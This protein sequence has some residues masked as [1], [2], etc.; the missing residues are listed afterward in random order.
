ML[1]PLAKQ[2]L[3]SV[4]FVVAFTLLLAV[5][6]LGVLHAGWFIGSVVAIALATIYA[7]VAG[8]KREWYRFD[9]PA[10]ALSLAAVAM[11]LLATESRDS[12]LMF[13]ALGPVLNF[14]QQVAIRGVVLGTA[15]AMLTVVWPAL[16]SSPG[17]NLL[18]VASAL[19][20]A[21][22]FAALAFVHFKVTSSQRESMAQ[23]IEVGAIRDQL[24]A[25]NREHL[26][27]LEKSEQERDAAEFALRGVWNAVTEQAM[28]TTDLEGMVVGWN[29]G[30][31]KI[32]GLTAEQTEHKRRAIDFIAPGEITHR[33]AGT[34]EADVTSAEFATLIGSALDGEAQAASWNV[35]RVDGT[36]APVEVTVTARLD[37]HG[38]RIGYMF[39]AHD[40]SEAL[41]VAKLKDEF[42]GLISHELRTPLSS[43]LGYLELLREEEDEGLTETQLQ[44]LGVAERNAH[45]LLRLVGDLLFTAQVEA[46]SFHIDSSELALAPILAGSVE[47]AAPAAASGGVELRTEVLEDAYVNGDPVRL[48]QA[49]DNLV[50]NAIKFTPRGGSV[51]VTLATERDNAVITVSDTGLG[52]PAEEIDQLFGRFF[53]ASTA[54]NNA[55]PGVGL[56]LTIT[57]AIVVAHGGEMGVDS[58]VGH[59][60]RFRVTLPIV[61]F[62]NAFEPSPDQAGRRS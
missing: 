43:I 16:A 31:E 39:V 10:P 4:L 35:M 5:P 8:M 22:M 32:T 50:S 3:T 23:L 13:L 55:V 33:E 15:G 25:S 27:E 30:A 21:S 19:L 52:I 45:R 37:E 11:I 61:K 49:V 38:H 59:G 42:V 29:P 60:T 1:P 40:I 24:L 62:P 14:S 28:V 34:G 7:W 46:G 47:T 53:R 44:Y 41:A 56:G 48:G 57:R 9:W 2:G 51:I 20:A 58:E 17:D 36:K 12:V 54:T 6:Q 18:G 26:R